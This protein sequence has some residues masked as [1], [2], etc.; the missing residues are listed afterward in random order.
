MLRLF[1]ATRHFRIEIQLRQS[2]TAG[3]PFLHMITSGATSLRVLFRENIVPVFFVLLVIVAVEVSDKHWDYISFD[4]PGFSLTALGLLTTAF[5]IFLVFR[6]NE[7]YARWWEA[8]I[9]W[10]GVV[11]YSRTFA[12]Q[13]TTLL[14]SDDERLHDWQQELVYRHLAYI[15][16]VRKTLRKEEG[17]DELAPYVSEAELSHLKT[18]ANKATQLLQ[19]QGERVAELR[20]LGVIDQFG[21]LMFDNS[22]SELYNLQGGCERIKNT[23]FPD[24]VAYFTRLIAWS[25]AV[26]I[27]VCV[28]EADNSEMSY[29]FLDFLLIPAIMLIFI[30]TERLGA[31]LKNPFESMPN[32]TPMT[33]LCRT[34][35]I[36]LR[37]QLGE[38]S[39]PEPIQPVRGVLM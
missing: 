11:N 9:L 24:R 18:K 31:D 21:H 15:N 17:W 30:V 16:A 29:D 27:P 19:T 13:A 23:V 39:V 20:E 37:Q 12:R 1:G 25:M 14:E 4:K 33:A 2:R 5:S 8:R 3:T 6:V 34:I 36:D 22:L 38:T 28:L 10:G 32:D 7:A 35:E 26:L